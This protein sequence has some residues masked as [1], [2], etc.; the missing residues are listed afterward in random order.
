MEP[1]V[2]SG[3]APVSTSLD[4]VE[5]F[6]VTYPDGAHNA[7]TLFVDWTTGD[8]YIVSKEEDGVSGVF[9]AK[10]LP[11][12]GT[13][14]SLERVATLTF[15]ADPLT[16]SRSTTGG[17]M[18]RDG[19]TIAIRTYSQIFVWKRDPGKSVAEAMQETLC[20]K[21]THSERQGE[22][23][24]IAADGKGIFTPVSYT[25]LTLPTN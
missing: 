2:D 18:S 23:V 9:Y 4:G 22:S 7:E 8:L 6:T 12:I 17:D 20:D 5:A 19:A 3:Q 25:H 11:T 15:G 10:K 1:A 21:I 14:I 13:D 16:G 24:A